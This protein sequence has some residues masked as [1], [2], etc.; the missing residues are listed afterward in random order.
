MEDLM[1]KLIESVN[2]LGKFS[3]NEAITLFSLVAAWVT[4]ILLLKDKFENKRPYLQITFELIRDNLTCII[5]RNV[6]NVPLE[7][8]KLKLDEKFVKQLPE[9]EQQG[10]LNNNINNMKIFPGKQ[11][12]LCLGVIVP[13]ILE[14]YAII[15]L[16]VDYEYSKMGKKKKYK[17]STEIDFKQ[18]SRMLV[19]VSEIDELRNENKKIE[20]EMKNITKKVKNIRATIVQYANVEDT[21]TKTIVN[22]Y[23][24]NE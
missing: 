1:K 3:W 23:E 22:G 6:G 24:K 11:W 20:K 17:E 16:N 9:R 18:Y 12:I 10:L 5:L 2:N 4:I 21:H 15:T 19:Y 7:I 14:K 8:K 13:E